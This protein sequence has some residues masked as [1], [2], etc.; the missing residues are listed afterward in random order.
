MIERSITH[1]TFSLERRY[2]TPV[3]GVFAAWADPAAKA[4]WFAAPGGEHELDFRIGGREVNR[5]RHGD[6]PPLT[7]ESLYQ[8]V[9]PDER[10]V[11]SSTLRAGD[12]LTTVSQTTVEFTPDGD[13][14]LLVLTEQGTFLDGHEDP[15]WREQGTAGWLDALDAEL[16]QRSE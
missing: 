7:F 4:R 1:G 13:G 5:G 8:D 12:L 15:A 11:Y 16:R 9:V 6:G 10:I 3:A 14:T 2:P